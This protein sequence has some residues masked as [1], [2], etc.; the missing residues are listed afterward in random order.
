M[1]KFITLF[2]GIIL[3]FGTAKSAE[4]TIYE[5]IVR[6]E[7]AA[8]EDS[9]SRYASAAT[10]DGDILFFQALIEPNAAESA[11]LMEAALKASVSIRYRQELFYRL[12][13]YYLVTD[14]FKQLARVVNEYR[15]YWESGEFDREMTRLSILVDEEAGRRESALRQV[16]RYLVE[17]SDGEPSQWG[18]IDKARLMFAQKKRIGAIEMLRALTREQR[19]PGIPQALYLL[20]IDAYERERYDDAVFYYNILREAYPQSVGLDV[21]ID[22]LGS[23]PDKARSD[24]TAE[25]LTGTYYSVKVGVFSEGDNARRQRDLFEKYGKTVD[26][27][28]KTISGKSYHVVYV[29]RF[30]TYNDALQFKTTLEANHG[31]VYQVVAR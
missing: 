20:A 18:R 17:Y 31:E 16:D 25:Q 5:L 12:A 26:I 13:Q 11:R 3:L 9:L 30:S 19:G 27:G 4:S 2:I 15:T 6:G 29:G 22:R 10:R 14:Q 8:A 24:N 1:K 23:I 28:S 7:L 21:L